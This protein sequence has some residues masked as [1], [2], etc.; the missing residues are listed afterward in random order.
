LYENSTRTSWLWIQELLKSWLDLKVFAEI[1]AILEAYVKSAV[2]KSFV[3]QNDVSGT[4]LTKQIDEQALAVLTPQ[5][6]FEITQFIFT[7]LCAWVEQKLQK[8]QKSEYGDDNHL[9]YF[10]EEF[11]T[12]PLEHCGIEAWL[13]KRLFLWPAVEWHRCRVSKFHH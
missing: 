3:R 13:A 4:W 7:G 10:V 11:N 1:L 6:P 2:D 5:Y 8:Y 12:T 9:S